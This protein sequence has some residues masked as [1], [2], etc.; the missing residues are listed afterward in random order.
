MLDENI[1]YRLPLKLI[2]S[3]TWAELNYPARAILPVIGVHI[4]LRV[5]RA[6]PGIKLI[7]R[8]SG[9]SNRE[10]IRNGIND[11]IN[12]NLIIKRKEGRHS[13]YYLTDLSFSKQGSSYFPIYKKAMIISRKWAGLTPCEKSLYPVLGNKAKVNDPEAL[14][15]EY[16][17][18]GYIDKIKKYV[19]WSGVSRRSFYN[20]CEGLNH[21]SLIEFWEDGVFYSYGCL[22]PAVTNT[23]G[24]AIRVAMAKVSPTDVQI[25]SPIRLKSVKIVSPIKCAKSV[26]RSISSFFL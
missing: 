16:H 9:Y 23:D 1:H 25:V 12:H 6:R 5:N 15:S 18:V 13:I 21:K 26:P 17:A 24:V 3:Y 7:S 20:A 2:N 14:E 22:C 4:D 19:E 10:Y 8:L 11:L